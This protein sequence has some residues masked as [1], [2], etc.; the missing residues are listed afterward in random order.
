MAKQLI[1]IPDLSR[2]IKALTFLWGGFGLFWITVEG[3]LAW[4]TAMGI[5]TTA[6]SLLHLLTRLQGR[7]FQRIWWLLGTAVIGTI[8]G[9]VAVGLTLTFMAVKTGLHAHGP[10]FFPWDINWLF[11]Q[12]PLWTTI[13]LLLGISF[14]FFTGAIW[15]TDD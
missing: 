13:G 2:Y 3:S 9:T 11:Q 1:H 7:I 6:V 12:P 4:V 10:E 14:G 15:Q 5:S 8:S